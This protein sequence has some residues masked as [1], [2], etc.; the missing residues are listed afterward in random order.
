M[1]KVYLSPA[2]HYFNTCALPGCDETTHNNL[3]LDEL[4]PYLT[5]CGIDFRRGTRR[6]PK[7]A[8]N[9][10]SLMFAAVAESNAWGADV[11]YISHTNAFDGTVRGYRPIIYTGSAK[12]K[13]LAEKII[14]R[15]Q[16]IYDQPIRLNQRMDLYEL[17]AVKAVSYYEEHVFHDNPED[18][19]WFHDH[20]RDIAAATAKGLCDY[21][22]ISF[23]DPYENIVPEVV[24]GFPALKQGDQGESVRALQILL[25]G[26]GC[27]VGSTDGIFGVNTASGLRRYQ[28]AGGL[29]ATGVADPSTWKKLLGL[30][31]V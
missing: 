7:S 20:L 22:A 8:E 24:T 31:A 19:Q 13:E 26:N 5:A 4:E 23:V 28:T 10:D 16:E 30:S 12:G 25:N 29:S 11:H 17:R 6:I 3:Y 2:Y 27:I 18:A 9:A 14:A 1:P 21:F 15:R